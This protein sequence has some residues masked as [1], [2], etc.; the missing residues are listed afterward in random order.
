MRLKCGVDAAESL[1]L[2]PQVAKVI[3][4][5]GDT[6][7][8]QASG[9]ARLLVPIVLAHEQSFH[10]G[11]VAFRPATREVV[12]AGQTSIIEPRVMQLLVALHR[13]G[14]TVVSKDD[15]LQSCW[16]GRVVGEDAINRVISR[17]RGVAEKEAGRQFRI[18]TITKVGYRLLSAQGGALNAA[19]DGLSSA[20]QAASLRMAIPPQR[21][22]AITAAGLLLL[23][24]AT[25]AWWWFRPVPAA[26]HIMMVRLSEF[27]PLSADL[28]AAMPDS[29]K[30]ELSAAFNAD[31]VVGVSAAQTPNSAS[32]PGYKLDGT[33]Y[34]VGASVRVIS[35]LTNE[36]SGV[37]LWSGSVD[38]APDQVSKAPHK[39]AA[40]VGTV[41]RCGL[42]GAATYHKPLP[43]PVLSNYL[44][45]CQEYWS[46]GGTR[47]LR[48][49]QRVVA[50]VPDFSWGWSAVGN[51]F[52]Q[53]SQTESN[54]QR[55]EAMRAAGRQAEDKALVLDHNNSEALAHK[56][57]LIDPRDW[58]AQEVLFKRAIKARP[59]DC[60]CEH[61]GYGLKLESVGRL[62]A[63]I[64]QFR[65]ATDMLALWPDSQRALAGALLAAGRSDE[66]GPYFDAAIN[67]SKDANLD[68]WIA[69]REGTESGD[70][71]AAITALRNPLL[72]VSKE[73]RPALLSGYE[74][75]ASGAPQAR[76]KAIQQLLA[77]PEDQQSGTVATLLAALGANQ[78][79]LR[80]TT[81]RPSLLWHRSMRGVLNEPA[82]P[83]VAE[84]IGLMTYWRTSH[85]KPDICLTASAPPFC[86]MI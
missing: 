24:L 3:V 12:F 61:Y 15:L 83:A 16:E 31:G 73:S 33:I 42:T 78:A 54:S 23:V 4:V 80:I 14:G 76:M 75:L 36:R 46:W 71:A 82:F 84:Q 51:G 1:F 40:D 62:G 47:T 53:A 64:V 20:G 32:A 74:A 41:I 2:A 27:R 38:Y 43:D 35:R 22:M 79:A 58:F 9:L 7:Q 30:A 72:N 69:V 25:G 29:I 55:A 81:N 10:I 65:A 86:R 66:A 50:A 5:N 60:G 44:Q 77:L 67:L 85:T 13:A 52:M 48:F 21:A 34:R 49:A 26:A 6:H 57:H 37:V 68:K 11:E 63:A 39:I 17:L 59:L 18:E 56:A 8:S 19:T 45:Y 28:P 70:Y